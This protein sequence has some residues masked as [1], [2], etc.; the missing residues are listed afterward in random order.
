[1]SEDQSVLRQMATQSSA[2][3]PNLG[4]KTPLWQKVAEEA[5]QALSSL[6]GTPL[7]ASPV[8]LN[9][10]DSLGFINDNAEPGLLIPL[11]AAGETGFYARM[12]GSDTLWLTTLLLKAWDTAEGGAGDLSIL[13]GLLI[14]GT[15]N[16]VLSPIGAAFSA[17]IECIEDEEPLF[18]WPLAPPSNVLSLLVATFTF[19]DTNGQ[20]CELDIGL[21]AHHDGFAEAGDALGAPPPYL[22]D[23]I[24]NL[25]IDVHAVL[26]QWTTSPS[27]IQTLQVGETLSLKGA[28]L[29]TLA[30]TVSSNGRP[31]ILA[32]GE[33]GRASGRQAIRITTVEGGT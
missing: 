7:T 29:E 9:T 22:L 17:D 24:R 18:E 31:A 19:T 6:L 8:T 14:R 11:R 32:H 20:S 28:S 3:P 10:T 15:I 30:L 25:P 27:T 13:D 1:M 5:A 16:T 23:I 21:P 12:S 2:L 33:H 4:A 26:D